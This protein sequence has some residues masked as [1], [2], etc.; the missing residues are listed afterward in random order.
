MFAR[1][2]PVLSALIVVVILYPAHAIAETDANSKSKEL[3]NI[4]TRIKAVQDALETIDIRKNTL[5][6]ELRDIERSYGRIAISLQKLEKMAFGQKQRLEHVRGQRD[7]Q[8]SLIQKQS[9]KLGAQ[10]RAVYAMGQQEKLKLIMNQQDP[11]KVTRMMVYFD[12]L[13]AAR[14]SRLRSF[15]NQ[16]TELQAVE[17][18]LNFEANRLSNLL[19]QKQHE[20]L[21]LTETDRQRT[22]LLAKLDRQAKDQENELVQL[23]NDEQRLQELIASIRNA[24]DDFPFIEGPTK[25]FK[26]LR[27]QL[28]WP[29]KGTLETK[30]GSRRISGQWDGVVIKAKEGSRVRVVSRGRVAYADWLRGYGL[31]MIIDH[32]DGFMTLYAFNQS[33][34]K[35]VGD[36][37]ESGEMIATV[38]NSGGRSKSG[39]YFGIRQKGKPVNPTK[40][41]QRVRQG[42]VG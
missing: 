17:N 27:G 8:Q 11:T 12:Y 13:N 9:D 21:I 1:S 22:Q 26:E 25:P 42:R 2:L 38:G 19:K 36:W 7:R 37:V 16:L 34:Y 10:L 31:L 41:C 35:E 28:K 3:K 20:Q 29:V 14:V 6:R 30:F 24:M 5:Y 39:L 33:L 23:Q 40:W 15:Q 32:G 4:Q 18:E